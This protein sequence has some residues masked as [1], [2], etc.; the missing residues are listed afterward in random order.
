MMDQILLCVLPKN[1]IQTNR[2]EKGGYFES[3]ESTRSSGFSWNAL[4]GHSFGKR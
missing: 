4:H 3:K 1:P 2:A